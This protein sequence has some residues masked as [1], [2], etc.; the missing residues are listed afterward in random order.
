[1]QP[2]KSL[3]LEGGKD[4]VIT[5]MYAIKRAVES[6][7][8]VEANEIG[9]TIMGETEMPNILVYESAEGSL[10]ILSQ[11]VENPEIYKAVMKEAF[12]ICFI[13]DGIEVPEE[14][15][16]PASYDDLLSY[17]N[18]IHHQVINRNYIR[19]GLRLLKDSKLEVLTTKQYSSYEEQYKALE[20]ARDKNSST[21]EKF[22]KYLYKKGI[23]LPDEAQPGIPDMFVRPDF[24]YKPNICVF[25]DGTPHDDPSV[26]E[27]DNL[28]R[29]TLKEAGYQVITWYYRDSL[30]ELISRRPDIFKPVK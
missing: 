29:S 28:K 26:K 24:F 4:G 11:I 15:L 12:D 9:V 7:F 14:E 17:Y 21:E 5:L 10:G 25:C 3:P 8:Q 20:A 22:L 2:V 1:M 27:D 19:E 16:V 30:D 23:R 18:Q 13:K 6:Y